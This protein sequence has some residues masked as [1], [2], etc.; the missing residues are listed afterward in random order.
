MG[1]LISSHLFERPGMPEESKAKLRALLLLW[2]EHLRG[3]GQY[4]GDLLLFSSVRGGERPG[5]TVQPFPRFRLIRGA[6]F[7]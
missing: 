2:Y 4:S 1:T 3:P 6:P 5:L 7:S